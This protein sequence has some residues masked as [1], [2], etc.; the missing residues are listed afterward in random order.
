MLVLHSLKSSV[1]QLG[2]ILEVAVEF[3][4]AKFSLNLN[5]FDSLARLINY[6]AALAI[7]FP[8]RAR[9]ST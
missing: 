2:L 7:Y 3:Y 6:P 1:L 9:N 8:G 5:S 4:N